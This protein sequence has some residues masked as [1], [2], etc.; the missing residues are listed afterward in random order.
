MIYPTSVQNFR[1]PNSL[2]FGVEPFDIFETS[3]LERSNGNDICVP[4]DNLGQKACWGLTYHFGHQRV[5]CKV[6]KYSGLVN[7]VDLS[8]IYNHS[9]FFRVL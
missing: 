8:L 6:R 1:F 7:I 2:R 9:P 3:A 4:E 5:G